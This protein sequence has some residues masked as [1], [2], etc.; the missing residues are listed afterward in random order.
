[1]IATKLYPPRL[2]QAPVSREAPLGRLDEARAV[3]LSLVVAPAG[4]GKSTL[5]AQWL[6]RAP[7]AAGWVCLDRADNDPHRFW[8]YV[9]L[10]VQQAVPGLADAA[11]TVLDGAGSDVVR[12]VLPVFVSDVAGTDVV[13]VLDDYH[14][15]TNPA[16]HN[17]VATLLTHPPRGLHLV[18]LTRSDPPLPLSRLRVGGSMVEIRTDQLHFTVPEATELLNDRLGLA[19]AGPDVTLLVSRT[20]G[21]A[22]GLQLAAMR[23]NDRTDRSAFISRFSGA[24]R[25]VVDYL[26]EEVLANQPPDMLDFLLRTSVLGRLCGPLC[27]AVTGRPDSAELLEAG[28]RANLFLIPLDAE[29]HWFR[30]HQLFRDILRIE[31]ARTSPDEPAVLHE[32]AARWYAQ[33][34]H[35]GES[36]GHAIESGNVAFTAELIATRWRRSFNAGELKTVETWLAAVPS[37]TAR[38]DVRLVAARVWLAMDSGRLDDVAAELDRAERSLEVDGHLRL[39]RALHTFKAGDVADSIRQLAE[40]GP[41]LEPFLETVRRLITGVTALWSG[42]SDLARDR[43]SEAARLAG[44]DGNRLA[45]I[46]AQGSRALLAVIAGDLSGAA[47]MLTDAERVQA[48]TVS[49]RHFVAMF[50]ALARARLAAAQQD[51]QRALPAARTAAELAVRGAGRV[52][53]A[54]AQLTLAAAV[55]RAAGTSSDESELWLSRARATLG[56]CPNPGPVVSAWLVAEQRAGR[57]ATDPEPL[58]DRELAI[59]KLLPGPMSQRELALSLFVT[60]N[61]L[62]THLRAIYRK[63]DADSRAQAVLRAHDLGLLSVPDGARHAR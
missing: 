2:R 42:D 1:V 38:D 50:P 9:L 21:W 27:A 33:S 5:V 11:L 22:A 63:L 48:D 6:D 40:V 8:R 60:P 23:L 18:L 61:T 58:T 10:A 4:W 13:I 54:A 29:R 26:G 45:T 59:L 47:L 36:I 52:E 34:G 28:Y 46:Y 12:D 32:R 53:V 55:R 57:R 20:E 49:D 62:K 30:Y 15:V 14:L 37:S 39:L 3:P 43:L 56:R 31:L 41:T 51:W 17:G 24:D 35:D 16:V 19:L 44:V 7:V 25:H